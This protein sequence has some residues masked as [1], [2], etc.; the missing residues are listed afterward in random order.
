M[1]ELHLSVMK[2]AIT[3]RVAC[4]FAPLLTRYPS[5]WHKFAVR[6]T[7]PSDFFGFMY[8]TANGPPGQ[9]LRFRFA[10]AV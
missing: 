1:R 9:S 7:V 3:E 5:M 4:W 2:N 10:A 6:R 8:S